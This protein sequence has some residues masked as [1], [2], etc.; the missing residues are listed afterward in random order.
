MKTAEDIVMDIWPSLAHICGDEAKK[1]AVAFIKSI[2]LDAFKAGMAE[3]A[4]IARS[5]NTPVSLDDCLMIADSILCARDQKEG[6]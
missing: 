3:A 2:Q 6:V 4:E 5:N 1:Q